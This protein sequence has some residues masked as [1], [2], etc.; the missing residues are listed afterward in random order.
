MTEAIL[1]PKVAPMGGRGTRSRVRNP[2]SL[3]K[4]V[5]IFIIILSAGSALLPILGLGMGTAAIGAL[6]MVA[7]TAEMIAARL[8]HESRL[9]AVFAGLVTA[10]AGLLLM[11]NPIAGLLRSVTVVTAWLLARSIIIA[12]NSRR[13]HGR[14]KL[15]LGLSA[16]TDLVLGLSSLTGLSIT[17]LYVTLF[18]ESPELVAGF[19]WV[20]ALSF[21]ATGA[22]LLEVASCERKSA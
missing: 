16:A 10:L 21:V 19:G 4:A 18:G 1:S 2:A 5:G 13:A 9:L 15:W 12:F 3:I 6:L 20:L 17:T 8:R 14:V 7:G 11:V 22:M